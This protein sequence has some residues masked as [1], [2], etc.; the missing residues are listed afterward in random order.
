MT[1]HVLKCLGVY[2]DDI[3]HG[4]KGF[5]VRNDDRVPAFETGDVVVLRN[6]ES[7]PGYGATTIRRIGYIARGECIPNGYCVFALEPSKP[8]DDIRAEMAMGRIEV[9]K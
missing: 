4:R 6:I 1:V 9:S 2:F 5:E 8:G 3:C 7:G